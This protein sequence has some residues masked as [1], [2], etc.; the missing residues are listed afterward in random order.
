MIFAYFGMMS[1]SFAIGS[2]GGAMVANQEVFLK[3]DDYR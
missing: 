1:M 2:V 3:S